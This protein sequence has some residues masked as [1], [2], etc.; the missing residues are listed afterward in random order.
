[1][2]TPVGSGARRG[3]RCESAES[4]PSNHAAAGRRPWGRWSR[5]GRPRRLAAAATETCGRNRPT[6]RSRSLVLRRARVS[7]AAA[8]PR[9]ARPRRPF[10]GDQRGGQ[11]P[12]PTRTACRNRRPTACPARSRAS[13][14]PASAA[15]C[16]G[17]Y[18]PPCP[19]GIADRARDHLDRSSISR[20]QR[21][22][23]PS[24]GS[25]IADGRRRCPAWRVVAEQGEQQ[26]R[27]RAGL[28]SSRWRPA[29]MGRSHRAAPVARGPRRRGGHPSCP[30]PARPGTGRGHR[31]RRPAGALR[32]PRVGRRPSIDP[33]AAITLSRTRASDR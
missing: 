24:S 27:R 19:A 33:T 5:P 18:R 23:E 26:R 32:R 9:A 11:P 20:R 14:S 17:A 7:R 4:V 31:R 10:V 28:P 16:Q 6:S 13:S 15:N 29:S 30:A 2:S 8:R 12:R 21:P 25:T 1:M 3:S 22:P